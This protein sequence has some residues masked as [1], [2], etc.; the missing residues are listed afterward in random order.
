MW[1]EFLFSH[2]GQN[3]YAAGGV[4]PVRADNMMADGTLDKTVAA[5]I[6]VIDGPVTVPSPQQTDKATA[7]LADHWAEAIG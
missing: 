5:A 7:Y 4:R 2:E 6:P 1:Q 3:L